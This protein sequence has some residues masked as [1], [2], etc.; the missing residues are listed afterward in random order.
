MDG[1]GEV[2]LTPGHTVASV[3]QHAALVSCC[4]SS[5]TAACK[6]ALAPHSSLQTQSGMLA[7]FRVKHINKRDYTAEQ[8]MERDILHT[9]V[10]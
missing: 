8:P 4:Y 5:S 2:S 6:L 10:I 9:W 7:S 1:A 3:T